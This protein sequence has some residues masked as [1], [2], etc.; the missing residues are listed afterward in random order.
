[1]PKGHYAA[2]DSRELPTF[3]EKF[4]RNNARLFPI[5]RL[6]VELMMLTFVRTG[7][8]I[9]AEWSEFDFEEAMWRIP[10]AR[11]KMKRD[12]LVPL[13]HRAIDILEQLR[14]IHSNQRCLF[15]SQSKPRN[16]MSNNTI[17]TALARMGYCG[18]MTGH[19]FRALAMSTMKEKLGYR[20]E[21]IDQ[22]AACHL[23]QRK[24]QRSPWTISPSTV[25]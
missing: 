2:F 6:A 17:L 3:L 21:V 22:Q 14:T 4:H 20:H 19:G 7:E 24:L 23:C 11:M 1:M 15:P 9:K 18:I 25:S 13:S 16:H 12:H 5:T 10:A 8:L